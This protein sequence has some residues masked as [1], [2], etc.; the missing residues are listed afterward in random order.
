MSNGLICAASA[1]AGTGLGIGSLALASKLSKKPIG[2]KG[3]I[4][5][6]L[7]NDKLDKQAKVD[8]FK[9]IA[10]ENLK[11]T[12]KVLGIS[13]GYAGM[14]ALASKSTKFPKI[15]KMFRKFVGDKLSNISYKGN[16]LKSIIANTTAYKKFNAL[17]RPAKA[18][19]AYGGAALA[20]LSTIFAIKQTSDAGYIE[21]QH[22]Q[23]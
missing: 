12:G 5:H 7:S 18:A 20:A 8:T 13:A 14:A 23:K 9:D 22:E 16:D 1:I 3:S 17:P 10:K 6:I 21:A 2:C 11:D 15:L 4:A 19:I